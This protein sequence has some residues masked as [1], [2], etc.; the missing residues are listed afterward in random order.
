MHLFFIVGVR[1]IVYISVFENRAFLVKSFFSNDALTTFYRPQ[2]TRKVGDAFG[3]HGDID[4]RN[5]TCDSFRCR[6]RRQMNRK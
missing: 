2:T 1:K 6:E 4:E 3:L 5:A